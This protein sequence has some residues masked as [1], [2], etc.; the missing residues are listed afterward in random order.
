M[1]KAAERFVSGAGA[2]AR[3]AEQIVITAADDA[4]TASVALV[5]PS[6]SAHIT[7]SMNVNGDWNVLQ[8]NPYRT[9]VGGILERMW[10][11]PEVE[12]RVYV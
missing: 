2:A 8:S 3:I 11:P 9:E 5:S 6:T 1:L 12:S 7:V 10:I 4:G